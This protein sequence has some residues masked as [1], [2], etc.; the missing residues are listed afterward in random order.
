MA[1]WNFIVSTFSSDGPGIYA[2]YEASGEV[3]DLNS[4]GDAGKLTEEVKATRIPRQ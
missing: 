1:K 3:P 2:N 4:F